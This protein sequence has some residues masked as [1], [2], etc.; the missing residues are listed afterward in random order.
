MHVLLHTFSICRPSAYLLSP[1]HRVP[2][3]TLWFVCMLCS[4]ALF[5]FANEHTADILPCTDRGLQVIVEGPISQRSQ[6]IFL[7]RKCMTSVSHV[8]I[9]S[10][11]ACPACTLGLQAIR[12]GPSLYCR[13]ITRVRGRS[14]YGQTHAGISPCG[15]RAAPQSTA[16]L[17][18]C[19]R[20]QIVRGEWYLRPPCDPPW[21]RHNPPLWS[22]DIQARDAGL[23]CCI[24][25]NL[26]KMLVSIG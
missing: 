17:F 6:L 15:L 20:Q 3:I 1:V 4:R 22:P 9:S 7:Y 14:V 26:I 8:R 10:N 11:K 23:E 16:H 24:D 19:P 12:H 2:A 5:Y 13:Y 25:H 18:L 21:W